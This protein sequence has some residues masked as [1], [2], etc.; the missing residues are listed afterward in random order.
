MPQKFSICT[1]ASAC[2][3]SSLQHLDVASYSG[4]IFRFDLVHLKSSDISASM[5]FAAHS[6]TQFRSMKRSG[7]NL[8]VC[9][10]VNGRGTIA[11][12]FPNG[13]VNVEC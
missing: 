7:D 3:R 8:L 4:K 12:C 6:A 13:L 10:T 11:A 5:G 9:Q 1:E 2:C